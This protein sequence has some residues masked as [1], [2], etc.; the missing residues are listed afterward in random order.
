MTEFCRMVAG[1]LERESVTPETDFRAG[2]I[3]DS[4][5][6]FALIVA[7][8]QRYGRRL[9]VADLADMKTVADLAAAAGVDA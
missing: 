4:L 9:A 1:I 7:I 5:T 3:W 2:P 6:G 8:A